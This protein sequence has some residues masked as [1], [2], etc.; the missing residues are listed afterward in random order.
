MV[1]GIETIKPRRIAD[2][3]PVSP[4][5]SNHVSDSAIGVNACKAC[6]KVRRKRLTDMPWSPVVRRGRLACCRL[7]LLRAN[8]GE[9]IVIEVVRCRTPGVGHLAC[10]RFEGEL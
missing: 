10:R 8:V 3:V 7:F 2:D 9:P 1:A 5:R 6:E 4:V